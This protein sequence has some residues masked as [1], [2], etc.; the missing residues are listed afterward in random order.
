MGQGL[1]S[2]TLKQTEQS[3]IFSLSSFKASAKAIACSLGDLNKKKVN[4]E[5]VLGPIP[6]KRLNSSISLITGRGAICIAFSLI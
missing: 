5:A 2:V 6:G 1:S 4:R 3:F